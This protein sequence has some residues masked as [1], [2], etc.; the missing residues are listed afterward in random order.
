MTDTWALFIG[1]VSLMSVVG[2]VLA[3]RLPTRAEG[4]KQ[5]TCKSRWNAYKYRH[6]RLKTVG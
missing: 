4:K 6:K 1:V 2:L 5:N 3:F